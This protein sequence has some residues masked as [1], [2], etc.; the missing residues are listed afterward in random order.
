MELAIPICQDGY[1]PNAALLLSAPKFRHTLEEML[2]F[3][4]ALRQMAARLSYRI[5]A[6]VY[7]PYQ[8]PVLS[9]IEP[10][11]PLSERDLNSFLQGPWVASLACIRP[12]GTPHVIPIWHE[13]DGDDFYVAAWSGSKWADYLLQDPR[14]SL[15]V[16]EP[17]PP[18]RR[19]L[20]HGTAM[21]LS[22][23]DIPQGL[24]AL[25]DRLSRRFLGQPLSPDL[26]AR[27]WR[28]F[29][30]SVDHVQGWR[31]LKAEGA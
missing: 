4:E 28:A 31:G 27:P 15:T 25:L 10:T 29:R 26:A 19:V 11:T 3:V 17:W 12:D 20:A 8:G 9:K 13:F 21:L 5:G 16:D 30:L 7:A 22:E 18:H 24:Y 1:T 2:S 14:V 23:S 6:P